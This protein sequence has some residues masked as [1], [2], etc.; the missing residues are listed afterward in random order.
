MG[1][2]PNEKKS[3]LPKFV[4]VL[5]TVLLMV[6]I[7]L[8]PPLAPLTRYGMQVIGILVGVVY[9]MS[10]VDVFW[11]SLCAILA[12][13]ITSGDMAAVLTKSVGSDVVWGMIMI[14]VVLYALQTEGVAKFLANA[15]I[16]RKILKGRPW[17]FSFAILLGIS[18]IS[19]ISPEAG[20]L[21]FWEIIYSTCDTVGI[22]R[23]SRW[24]QAMIFG[25]CFAAGTGVILLPIMRNGLVVSRQFAATTGET[26]NTLKY[27]A[28]IFPLVVCGLIIYILLC[29]FVFRIDASALKNMDTSVVDKD[30]LKLTG[31][32]KFVLGTVLAMIVVLLLPSVLPKTWAVTAVLSNLGLFG[33]TSIMVLLYCVVSIGGQ[34]IVR[35]QEAAS[36]GVIWPM[37]FMTA[38]IIPIGSALTSPDAGITDLISTALTPMLERSGSWVFVLVLV[39]FGTILTNFAQ[40]LVIMSIMLPIMYAMA[41]TAGINIY[42][43]TILLAVAT[44]YACVL[45]SASPS[46]GMLFSNQYFKPTYAYKYGIITLLV[47]ILFVTTLGYAWVNLIF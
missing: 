44:H 31:R 29:K 5:I 7:G 1:T 23:D 16:S 25:S 26:M 14:F 2:K 47:C 12:L 42:A 28:G 46:A 41:P 15:I 17:L 37:V 39:L 40:N 8:L 45:P 13:A 24:G 4:H 34:P 32:Q 43:V 27:I 9:G 30:A 19:I 33:V 3:S 20:M 35:I 22:P 18:L 21:L 10:M 11:P 36:K 6:V 38:L